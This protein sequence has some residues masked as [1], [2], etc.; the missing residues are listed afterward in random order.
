MKSKRTPDRVHV[1][2][3][4]EQDT[5]NASNAPRGNEII[6]MLAQIGDKLKRSEAE[7][8]ELLR[9]LREYRK[10][11]RDLEDKSDNSEKAFLAIES[12][13][14]T[15][16]TIDTESLE[17]QGRLERTIK[18][19][20]QKLVTAIA[21]Q[22]VLDRR[23]KETEDKQSMI[24]QRL[25][26][27]VTEQARIDRQLELSSQ[28]R[29]RLVRKLERLE[30]MM[31]D[32]KNALNSKAMVL[33][34]DRGAAG[35]I[36]L[37]APTSVDTEL[38]TDKPF[39]MRLLNTQTLGMASMIIAALLGGWAINQVQQ[40]QVPQIAVLENGGLARLNL[41]ENRWE[42]IGGAEQA[43]NIIP[44]SGLEG[45]SQ[46]DLQVVEP[47]TDAQQAPVTAIQPQETNAGVLDLN[48][49]QLL[50]ALDA[51]PEGLAAELNALEPGAAE[52][53]E[54][55][56][57]PPSDTQD[58]VS[59][60]LGAPSITPFL[61]NFDSI[62]FKQDAALTQKIQGEKSSNPLVERITIDKSL[63]TLVK[64][65]ETQAFAGNGEAQHDLAAI[66]TAGHGGV[67]QN[68][69]RAALWFREAADNKI[70]NARYN[71][72]VLYHQ[73]LGQDRDL[74]RALY[75]YREAAKVNHAE[76]QYNLGIA[77]IEG[78]GTEY[79]PPLAAAFFERAA[80]NGV[81]E[82][83]YNLGLIFENGLLGEAKPNEALLWYKIAADQGVTDAKPAMEGLMRTLQID[84]KDVDNLVERMQQINQSVKGYRVGPTGAVTGSVTA[85]QAI[86][87]QIQ[88]FL[89]VT[90]DY[91][92]PADGIYGPNTASAIRSYQTTNKLTV[93]GKATKSLLTYMIG[94]ASNQNS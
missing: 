26:E 33:L 41:S 78:I 32:T 19:T 11:L 86:I 48:D 92:G 8:Y 15:K 55:V 70:G 80:N 7:R 10:S 66:Y 2:R 94:G 34:T 29:S 74:D 23:L 43:N 14:S 69:E 44:A 28:D 4:P 81:M 58:D 35:Q 90:G 45:D 76:A 36:A 73:G 49:D 65:I 31:S 3:P 75:W 83:A 87:A 12:K 9:E 64:E 56:A 47:L 84:A 59:A 77:H 57:T 46:S 37:S 51:N 6:R 38:N 50:E 30:E 60:V 89:M 53:Q 16:G 25:D 79:N 72:G 17:R 18:S 1:V 22:A 91:A 93:D 88:E 13:L 39:L 52:A 85:D 71:L 27:S 61:N 63:P 24:D 68:F 54:P 21:G 67:E 62:A 5:Y 40:P 20:E 82:A 42:A